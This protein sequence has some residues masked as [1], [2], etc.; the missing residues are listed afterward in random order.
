MRKLL[1]FLLGLG[2]PVTDVAEVWVVEARACDV[3]EESDP[4]MVYFD[5]Y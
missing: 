1:C 4:C 5:K 2:G 3:W